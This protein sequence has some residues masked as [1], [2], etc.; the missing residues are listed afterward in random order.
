M[1]QIEQF[2]TFINVLNKYIQD[3][4]NKR[5]YFKFDYLVD[6]DNELAVFRFGLFDFDD[7]EYYNTLNVKYT[8]ITE[9][10]LNELFTQYKEDVMDSLFL[11]NFANTK[12]TFKSV[13]DLITDKVFK[14]MKEETNKEYIVIEVK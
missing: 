7:K 11:N 2:E 9:D 3:T 4:I 5:S 12:G 8:G 13:K 14:E 1:E 6:L 10:N